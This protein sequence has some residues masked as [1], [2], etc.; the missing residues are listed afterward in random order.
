MKI[1]VTPEAQS[2]FRESVMFYER[3]Q[4]GLG[5]KFSEAVKSTL[6]FIAENPLGAEVKYLDVRVTTVKT[7]PFT[8][9]YSVENSYVLILAVFHNS[10]KPRK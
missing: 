4:K 6:Y 5:K 1:K 2:E 9:H 3:R 10:K 7:F 8:I